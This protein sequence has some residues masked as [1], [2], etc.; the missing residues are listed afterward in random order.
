[1]RRLIRWLHQ[2]LLLPVLVVLLVVCLLRVGLH[3]HPLYHQQVE[4][5]LQ[6]ALGQEISVDDFTLL[7]DGRQLAIDVQGVSIGQV[8]P[9]WERLAFKLDVRHLLE[10]QQLKLS[11]VQ[12]FGLQIALQ[13]SPEGE[14]QPLGIPDFEGNGSDRADTTPAA[15]IAL[16][17]QAGSL[18][19]SDG[20]LTL[21]PRLGPPLPLQN[22]NAQV[23]PAGERAVALQWQASYPQT[24]GSLSAVGRVE[25]SDEFSITQARAQIEVQRLPMTPL[26]QQLQR[27]DWQDGQLSAAVWVQVE[28]QATHIQVR[29]M[30]LVTAYDG[31]AV[32]LQGDADIASESDSWQLVMANI[33]GG[34]GGI[35]WPL[36]GLQVDGQGHEWMMSS[37]QINAAPI[38]PLLSQFVHLPAKA[39]DPIVGL[40]P[41]G[42]LHQ[43]RFYWHQQ[44]PKAF[45]FSAVMENASVSA[46]KGVPQVDQASGLIAITA[47]GGKV[48]IDDTDGLQVHLP[49]LTSVP[50][51]FDGMA[52]EVAWKFDQQFSQLQ[53][54]LVQLE[55]GDGRFN[56]QLGGQFPRRNVAAEAQLQIRLGLQQVAVAD[57]PTMLPDLTMGTALSD[58]LSQ[59]ATEGIIETGGVTF[60]GLL[61][62]SAKALGPYAY[63]VPVWG[64]AQLPKVT[65]S[66]QWPVMAEVDLDFASDHQQVAIHLHKAQFAK[67]PQLGVNN[68]F[69]RVP[70][71]AT[72]EAPAQASIDVAGQLSADAQ[73][74]L[75]AA[76]SL[77]AEVV[78]PE[79]IVDLQPQGHTQLQIQTAIPYGK[80]AQGKR[81][82]Y[83]LQI[84]GQG[85]D[86]YWQ[87]RQI[88]L[89]AV[90]LAAHVSN[91]GLHNLTA[92]GLADGHKVTLSR[93]AS[94]G[95]ERLTYALHESTLE[96][97]LS[98][99]DNGSWLR[100]QGRLPSAYIMPKLGL[101]GLQIEDWLPSQPQVDVYL[102]ECLLIDDRCQQVVGNLDFTDLPPAW[103]SLVHHSGS[104]SFAWHKQQQ[105]QQLELAN[106][107]ENLFLAFAGD[108]WQGLGVGLDAPAP[109][110]ALGTQINGYMDH[111]DGAYWF[112]LA[113]GDEASNTTALSFPEVKSVSIQAQALQWQDLLFNAALL[114]YESV[115]QGWAFGLLSD[116]FAGHVFNAGDDSPWLVDVDHIR[117][118]VPEEDELPEGVEAQDLLADIDPAILPSMDVEVHE[119]TKNER[120]LGHWSAKLRNDNGKVFVHDLEARIHGSK[121]SGNLIWS[122]T[123]SQHQT[124][125]SGRVVTHNVAETLQG[126][127]YS[128]SI[129]SQYGAVEVQL[130]WPK[131][132]LA[133]DVEDSTG[134]LALRVKQGQIAKTP[135][136]ANSLKV[137]SLLDMNR[138]MQRIRL[139]FTDVLNDEYV[140]NS[141]YA[142]YQF[143]DG[144]ARTV[145]PAE[146]KAPSLEL[147]L[148]GSINF[149]QRLVYHDLY[150]TIPVV[151]K[152]PLAALIAGLP[153]LGGTLYIV[154]KL[155]GNE[156]STFTSIRYTV[157]GDLD[158]PEVEM[159]QV[160]DKNNQPQSLD[161]R[162]NNVFKFQ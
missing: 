70:M 38:T 123:G 28:Q 141:I 73:L 96:A 105:D 42:T 77:P 156:L 155:I 120:S 50:W 2:L 37:E 11:Q 12:L 139:D 142:H 102:P 18:A 17:N 126:F 124:A 57:L 30:D 84:Q 157:A 14:W 137:L 63:S 121:L 99:N 75:T 60:N 76:A 31:V 69:I 13:E 51:S 16:L 56:L 113:Q 122:K 159:Q 92:Q 140:F 45:L 134:D 88:Q 148:E 118:T 133:F 66:P 55:Q 130:S 35:P 94:V 21:I 46:W 71:L 95:P 40:A 109:R 39:T 22:L 7:L 110:P 6:Q 68:W 132:P 131:S 78:V 119:I 58:Y 143:K 9:A 10:Y 85:L 93:R 72:A 26:W 145:T 36:T 48:S 135:D 114:T 64:Q 24:K 65:Y 146:F 27:D 25:L 108:Q 15:L 20:R 111:V 89:T 144:V 149:P 154:D 158:R 62:Q 116:E 115:D 81:P 147:S 44:Q 138:L 1:M 61:G 54:S 107:R 104:L 161:E 49:K 53:S 106:G 90:D 23:V 151:D 100:L 52:G 91:Q 125:F 86:G 136:V 112:N 87:E 5:W 8:G 80:Q 79:W 162:I 152:L 127:G 41:T 103:P 34:M 150:V 128:P 101:A 43:P 32:S 47:H 59:A 3:S 74:L 67:T 160:F 97:L 129:D 29:D 153:Q 98:S 83:D 19:L 33:A 4:S 82:S 117:V